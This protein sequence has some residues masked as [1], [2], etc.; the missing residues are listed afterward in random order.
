[1]TET[2]EN[3]HTKADPTDRSHRL[4]RALAWVGIA[5]GTLFIVATVFFSGY[6]LGSHGGGP[7]HGHHVVVKPFPGPEGRRGPGGPMGP[8]DG[9]RSVPLTPSSPTST[10]PRP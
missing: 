6:I 1:M 3:P 5:A 8:D 9:P 2:L 10:P 7:H 4:Y